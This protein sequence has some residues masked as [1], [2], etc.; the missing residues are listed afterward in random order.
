MKFTD[1]SQNI[2]F[3]TVSDIVSENRQQAFVIGGYVR[4]LILDRPSKDIDIVVEGS[5]IGL[6]KS[7]AKSISHGIH[8]SYFKSF[9]TAMF[10][11]EGVDYEFVGARRESYSRDSRKPI[12][13]DGTIEDDQIRRDFTINA[14]A[15]SLHSSN[16]GELI[17]PFN[18]LSDLK[19]G[20]IRTPQDPNI[21]F[22]DDPL[23]MLRAI[24]FACQLNFH[25]DEEAYSAIEK[26][27][28]KTWNYLKGANK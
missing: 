24:R 2:V 26:K 21:T 13:E 20:V 6:A 23:R 3:N 16:F 8:V 22:S 14:L 9:G 19:R 4:D 25:I 18:G 1:L 5:G 15:I 7:V 12:V 11:W 10:Q 17:D 27:C 28:G